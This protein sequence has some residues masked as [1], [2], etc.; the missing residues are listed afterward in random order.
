MDSSNTFA[1]L[2]TTGLSSSGDGWAAGLVFGVAGDP[3]VMSGHV[4]LIVRRI[5][6]AQRG[7]ASLHYIGQRVHLQCLTLNIII[8][9]VNIRAA[10]TGSYLASKLAETWNRSVKTGIPLCGAA[11][12]EDILFATW[13][14]SC[15]LRRV[16][17]TSDR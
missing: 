10:L 16:A 15:A 14:G 7:R 5:Q 9:C 1:G 4:Q 3:L 8:I 12:I 13:C 11:C 17:Q 2:W 6:F